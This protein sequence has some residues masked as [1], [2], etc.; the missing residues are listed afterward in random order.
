MGRAVVGDCNC[1]TLGHG[2]DRGL[3]SESWHIHTPAHELNAAWL[4]FE[5]KVLWEQS[6]LFPSSFIV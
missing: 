1:L 6:C 2:E 4:Y 5:D 3:V